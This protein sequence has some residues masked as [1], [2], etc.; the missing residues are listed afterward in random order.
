M[1]ELEKGL[2][3]K[4]QDIFNEHAKRV[5]R[6]L[7]QVDQYVGEVYSMSYETALVQIHDFHRMQVGGIPSLSFLIASRINPSD[8]EINYK[9]E[10][11]S[12]LLLRVMDA[13]PLPNSVEAERIRVQSAQQ[14][15]GEISTHWDSRISMDAQTHN[16][17]SFAGVNC[18]IIGTFFLEAT[19]ENKNQPL[20]LRFG[21]DI[22]NY[23]PNKGLKVFKPNGEALEEIVNYQ[24]PFRKNELRNQLRV[25]IGEV[26]YAST[27]REFQGVSNV[28][29]SISPADLLGQKSALFGM[30]RSGKSNTTKIIAKAVFDLRFNAYQPL[31]IGQVI[32]D[33][34]GEY[35]N[36]NVQDVNRGK[37]PNALKNVWQ[38]NAK[39]DVRDVVTYGILPHPNDRNR[40]LML[41]NFFDENMLQTGK[42]IINNVLANDGSKYIQNF[43]QVKFET[44]TQKEYGD[45]YYSALTRHKR[46]LL[47]YRTLLYKAG[48][49]APPNM[50]PDTKSLFKTELIDA[51]RSVSLDKR[52][53]KNEQLIK[54][55]AESL[56]KPSPSW[57]S[58]ATALEGLFY[59]FET[60]AYQNFNQE[61][62]KGSKTGESWAD[63]DLTRILEMFTFTKGANIIGQVRNQH[64]EKTNSDF[65]DDIYDDL[66]AGRL[67]VVD[68]SSGEPDVNDSSA[69]RIMGR[70][71]SGNQKLFRDGKVSPDILVY[72]EEAHNLL[73]SGSDLDLRDIWVRTAKEGAK[74]NLGMVYVTQEVSSIQRNILKNTANWFIGHLNNTDETREL[75]KFYDFAD[76][77]GSIIRAQDRGFLRVKT[78]SNL[79]VVPVQIRKFEV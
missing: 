27:N 3:G 32:F 8:D 71:F 50:T 38:S 30:T 53:S 45:E 36:E 48:F 16:L 54:S 1:N 78:L 37:N 29:V 11:A 35:A 7:V 69:R 34:N 43:R 79:F 74:Y 4:T 13:A 17:L 47:A 44:P 9:L 15:S 20:S 49:P 2:I 19:P 57:S 6:K 26:R 31:R 18:R 25:P 56:A 52:N 51:M 70:I 62:I 22:S 59:F 61:Y 5:F 64:T 24:D 21:S 14:V 72:I 75:K 68:Q 63:A 39:G 12:I 65:A 77:E 55:A 10:D 23:Y 40:K 60:D 33:P 67:V 41:I 42:E 46:R 58:L 76:F 66:I 73:P 28:Q